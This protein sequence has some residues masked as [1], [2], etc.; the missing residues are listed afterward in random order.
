MPNL[1]KR[2]GSGQ[3]VFTPKQVVLELIKAGKVGSLADRL[4]NDEI[5]EIFE[6]LSA[7]CKVGIIASRCARLAIS[8]TTPPKRACSSTLDAMT[9]ASNVRP[10]TI[11][12]AVSSHDVSIPKTIGS[13]MRAPIALPVHEVLAQNNPY[14]CLTLNTQETHINQWLQ[15]YLPL[16]RASWL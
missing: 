10:R 12:T 16:L 13:L 7:W 9:L 6:S 15:R 2:K 3:E 5:N 4:T 14:E 11:P 1:E 8:G